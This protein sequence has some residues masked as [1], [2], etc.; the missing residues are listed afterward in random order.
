MLVLALP[1]N[2]LTPE[3]RTCITIRTTGLKFSP[4]EKKLQDPAPATFPGGTHEGPED[5]TAYFDVELTPGRY[6]LKF[7]ITSPTGMSM[8]FTVE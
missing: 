1:Y 4:I 5:T 8:E 6:V 7:E 2:S 3:F